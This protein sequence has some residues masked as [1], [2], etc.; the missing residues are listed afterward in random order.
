MDLRLPLMDGLQSIKAIRL[1]KPDARI[2]VLTMSDGEH[3]IYSALEAGAMGYLLKDGPP[4]N[5]IQAIYNA[6]EGHRCIPFDVEAK[7]QT[8]AKLTSR[9]TQA[10]ELLGLG[11]HNKEIALRLSIG[12]E[13][14]RAHMK[15]AFRKLEVHDRTAAFA[16]VIKRGIVSMH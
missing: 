16:E 10:V 3:D 4:G 5:L 12:V 8:R 6:H 9:E 1:A 15:R 13:T 14:V 11:M 7:L 2:L